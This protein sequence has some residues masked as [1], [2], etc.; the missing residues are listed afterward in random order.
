MTDRPGSPRGVHR[1]HAQ[2]RLAQVDRNAHRDAGRDQQHLPLP[3]RARQHALHRVRCR[4]EVD[5]R[6][7]AAPER[8][9][10][11]L[12]GGLQEVLP[13]QPRPMRDQQP[14][15]RLRG[16]PALRPRTYRISEVIEARSKSGSPSTASIMITFSP[17]SGRSRPGT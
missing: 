12:D 8:L 3:V 9:P 11:D 4:R 14:S 7:L 13:L 2:R 16:Q 1:V 17:P 6:D 15:G 5:G 10:F